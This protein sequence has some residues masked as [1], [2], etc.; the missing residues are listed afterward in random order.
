MDREAKRLK[1]KLESKQLD[2]KRKITEVENAAASKPCIIDDSKFVEDLTSCASKEEMLSEYFQFLR[3]L[4][5]MPDVEKKRLIQKV[6]AEWNIDEILNTSLNPE[7]NLVH[8]K[9]GNNLIDKV[10]SKFGQSIQILAPPVKHCLLCKEVLSVNN[11]PTQIAVF[12]LKGPQIYSKYI[13]K[14][15]RC[16]LVEKSKFNHLNEALRQ[17]VFYHPDKYGTM[18]SGYMFYKQD[19]SHIRASNGVYLETD[20]LE[21][22]KFAHR[23]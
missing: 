23:K 7:V 15:Q 2:A 20:F 13:L 22:E 11:K 19:V 21:Y 9:D 1:K 14:C 16:R 3:N 12:G 8:L 4:P 18:K 6:K 5:V 10:S 17:D